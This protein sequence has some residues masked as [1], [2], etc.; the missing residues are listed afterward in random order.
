MATMV[1]GKELFGSPCGFE[2]SQR[3]GDGFEKYWMW[4]KEI[5]D[6]FLYM[7]KLR[8]G[9]TLAIGKYRLSEDISV[10]SEIKKSP[11]SLGF[12]LSGNIN[13]KINHE[14]GDNYFWYLNSGHRSI[15]YLPECQSITTFSAG[16]QVRRVSI[17]IDP[18]LLNTLLGGRQERIPANMRDIINGNIAKQYY[19]DSSTASP[20]VN[21]II[22][23]ILNCPYSN[24][25]KKLYFESKA[26]EL[27]A[28]SLQSF[29]APQ[30]APGKAFGMRPNDIERVRRAKELVKRDYKNPPNLLDLARTVGLSHPKLNFCFREV[31]GTTIFGYIRKVRLNQA[32]YLLDEGRLNVT[33]VAYE[34]GYSS[35]SHFAKVFKEH[36]GIAPSDYLRKVSLKLR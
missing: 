12:S 7:I 31:Y 3:Q 15:T 9:L 26:L 13:Y 4:P 19:H 32:K 35:L 28:H 33:E 6:G 2:D 22:H 24:P 11:I 5:G 29:V 17:L 36:F 18:G 23:Q 25:L 34:V 1:D 20:A 30:A 10:I 14:K 21:L 27:I 8:P 16:A